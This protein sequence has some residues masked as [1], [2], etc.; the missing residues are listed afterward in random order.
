AYNG[1]ISNYHASIVLDLSWMNNTNLFIYFLLYI[2]HRVNLSR[3][4]LNEEVRVSL[5]A[6]W[7]YEAKKASKNSVIIIGSLHLSLMAAVGIWLWSH[8]ARFGASGSCSLSATISIFGQQI[9]LGSHGLRIWSIL[10]Y[11][12]VLVPL[13]NLFIP[14]AF[15]FMPL[16]ILKHVFG[17]S[18]NVFLHSIMI[19]LGMLAVIDIIL[20]VDT[21]VA[22]KENMNRFQ[23]TGEAQWTF[24]QTLAL[25]LLLV[26]LRDLGESLLEKRAKQLDNQILEASKNG[27]KKSVESLWRLCERRGV[28]GMSVT[29]LIK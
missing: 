17:S 14:T 7:I 3:D 25:L 16:L 28:L 13:L 23:L 29:I 1:G 2:Y 22:I 11:S 18:K 24:G 15:F 4:D 10:V 5:L 6:R 21:E 12:T 26:A 20:L 8:P 9:N 27:E 19:G